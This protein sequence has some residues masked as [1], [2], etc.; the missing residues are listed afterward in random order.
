MG[1]IAVFDLG[2]GTFDIS[3]LEV[4]ENVV[5][6]KS[7]NGDTKLGGDDFD[8]L[9]IKYLTS[10]FNKE[11][12]ID[13][14]NDKVVLQRL[15]DAAEK[16]KIELSNVLETEINLP[17]LTADATGP[18][19]L[20][21]RLTRTKFENIIKNSIEQ[22]L[23]PCQKVIQDSKI[24]IKDIN[25]VI[26]VGGSTRIPLVQ[27]TV[28]DF[29]GKNP[30]KSVN[31]DEVVALGA[32]VQGGVLSGEVKD[33]LL[34][35]VTPLSLGI[36]T[37]GGVFTVLIPRN[38][39]IPHK[40]TEIFSTATD[41][42]S[43]V[44]VHVLQGER[45]MAVNNRTLGRFQLEGI[46]PASRGVPQIEVK[47]DI[48]ANGIVNVTAKDRGTNKEQKITIT[49]SST[50]T[51]DEVNRMVKEA[52]EHTE[53]DKK[54]RKIIEERNKLDGLIYAVK[55]TYNENKDKVSDSEKKTIED[56]IKNAESKISSKNLDEITK[57][58]DELTKI[59]HKFTDI[60]YKN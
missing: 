36:E 35:D 40:K 7:T 30:N 19:H 29:F 1:K 58:H 59:S 17:F 25:E 34:L 8:L 11:Y 60:L 23:I 48:D 4:C 53:D 13:I 43:S 14:S 27:K 22:T 51:E 42:Q 44:E 57:S 31:P 38:T 3:I 39:T 46:P 26:L 49:T 20:N 54:N 50:L 33:M 18:K 37:L 32:A 24:S 47:F 15:K 10:E 12:G 52:Q 45:D 41:N 55:K 6:V 5:E 9:L 16:A 2:G 21:I 56:S 28:K